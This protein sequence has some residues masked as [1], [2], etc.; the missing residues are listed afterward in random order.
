MAAGTARA[1]RSAPTAAPSPS[2]CSIRATSFGRLPFA[3]GA[4]R[5]ARRGPRPLRRPAGRRGRLRAPAPRGAGHRRRRADRVRPARPRVGAAPREPGLPPGPGAARAHHPRPR[6]PLR[7]DDADRRAHR[8]AGHA[9]P[10]GRA[11][12]DHA[13]D[14]DQGRGLATHRGDRDARAPSDPHS[15]LPGARGR[16]R[17][18]PRHARAHSPRRR[19][20][21]DRRPGRLRHRPR[22]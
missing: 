4:G 8:P 16:R 19:L 10:A 9:R 3:E 2:A 12:G 7:Q 17:G 14:A 5:G 21:H 22:S 11:R 18:H 13:R 15:R 20:T 1:S 6:R